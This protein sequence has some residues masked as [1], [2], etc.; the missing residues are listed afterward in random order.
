MLIDVEGIALVP[1]HDG[2]G[3]GRAIVGSIPISNC[4]LKNICASWSIL[5]GD[6][7]E[8]CV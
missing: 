7:R 6:T 2:E 1:I 5:L 4:E 3:E 8:E